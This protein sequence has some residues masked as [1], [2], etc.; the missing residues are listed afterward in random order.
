MI[1][2][3]YVFWHRESIALNHVVLVVLVFYWIL[4][5]EF[6]VC[7]FLMNLVRVLVPGTYIDYAI[8]FN[9]IVYVIRD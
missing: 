1:S 4:G 3:T 5:L 2:E 7:I 6:L 9:Y 8:K